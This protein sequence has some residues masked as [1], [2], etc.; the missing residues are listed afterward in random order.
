MKKPVLVIMAAGMGSRYGGMKQVAHVDNENQV[1]M[2]YSMYD[3]RRA[4]FE[5][6]VCIIKKSMEKDFDEKVGKN[7]KPF[8]EVE[9]AFQDIN[10]LPAGYSVPSGREKPWGT[11]HAVLSAKKQVD[12]APMAVINADDFYG[13]EAFTS[14][15][16]FLSEPHDPGQFA[17]V[18]YLLKNTVTD[19][20][21]VARGVCAVNS[22]GFLTQIDERLRIEKKEGGKIAY[23]EDEGATYTELDPDTIVSMN[24]WGYDSTFMEEAEKR[25]PVFLE[26]SI[27][28]NPMKCEFLVPR[29]TDEL[30]LEGKATVKV[31]SCGAKWHGVT[32]QKDMPELQAA[33]SEMKAQG[34]YPEKLWK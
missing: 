28:V 10:D 20:G 33:I 7:I 23:T 6:A 11:A 32:Y 22:N 5:K 18:G 27:P 24:F 14:I 2:D 29:V 19:N 13:R 3:A 31:L 16:Q 9:Y 25:F 26:K 30:V 12:G 15:Y 17:M 34:L 4:G 21:H 8:M 1:I